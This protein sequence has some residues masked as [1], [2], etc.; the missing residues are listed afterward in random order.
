VSS[1]ADTS[2]RLEDVRRLILDIAHK[3]DDIGTIVEI[4]K[5]GQQSFAAVRPKS[6]TP[7]RISG[8]AEAGTYSLYVPCS[9]S[10]IAQFR[11]THPHMFYYHGNRE[12]RLDLRQDMPVPELSLFIKTAL[13]YYLT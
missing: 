3:T 5:W 8:N 9:T 12:I 6:G 1:P 13:Q 11:D 10:L 2:Q 4:T 7:I